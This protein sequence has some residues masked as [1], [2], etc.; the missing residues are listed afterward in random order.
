[1]GKPWS[2]SGLKKVWK[3]DQG[4]ET[5]TSN[6]CINKCLVVLWYSNKGETWY[7][8]MIKY[9]IKNNIMLF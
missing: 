6:R 3:N 2:D 5:I 1:M 8:G 9:M 4:N 7:S